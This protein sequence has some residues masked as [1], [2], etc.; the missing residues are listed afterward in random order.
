[1]KIAIV[2]A[3]P[4]GIASSLIAAGLLE[5]AVAELNWQA[6]IECH[7]SVAPVTS[8]TQQQIAAAECIVIAANANVNDGRFI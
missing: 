2:T 5:K 3:C 8:L 6:D 1:M 4:S 7:S